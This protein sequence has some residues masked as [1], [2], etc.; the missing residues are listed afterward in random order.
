[1]YIHLTV[2]NHVNPLVIL[3][4][5]AY[6]C[7]Q[8]SIEIYTDISILPSLKDL[9]VLLQVFDSQFVPHFQH[10]SLCC[11]PSDCTV[12]S[13][14]FN[15]HSHQLNPPLGVFQLCYM[16][17]VSEFP[18]HSILLPL[19]INQVTPEKSHASVRGGGWLQG[20]CVMRK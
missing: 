1:M 4:G 19:L 20:K 18:E 14:K 16:V 11:I 6:R 8:A 13:E 5:R 10:L 7:L 17:C 15:N 2:D 12:I 3:I 9:F